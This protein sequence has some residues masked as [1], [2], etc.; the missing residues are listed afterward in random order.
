MSPRLFAVVALE[1]LETNGL[2]GFSSST[3]TTV[4]PWLIGPYVDA[5]AKIFGDTAGRQ[6]ALAWTANFEEHLNE[7][8]LGQVSEIFDGDAHTRP[9]VVPLKLGA[10]RRSHV[11]LCLREEQ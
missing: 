3:V 6:F 10:S 9:E 8:C 5:Y 4:W 7:V 11:S 1:W 2:G